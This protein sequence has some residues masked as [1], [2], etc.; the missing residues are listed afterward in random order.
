MVKELTVSAG[1]NI[2]VMLP[3]NEVELN[4]FVVPPPSTGE[5]N[6]LAIQEMLTHYQPVNVDKSQVM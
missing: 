3:K 5:L 1:D 6:G 2:Q 4:A